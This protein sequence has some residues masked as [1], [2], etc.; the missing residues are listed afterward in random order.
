MRNRIIIAVIAFVT[1]LSCASCAKKEEDN[2]SS[3]G[4]SS[5]AEASSESAA[6]DS[7]ETSS[8]APEKSSEAD[9]QTPYETT[10]Q[11]TKETADKPYGETVDIN[12]YITVKE[13]DPPMWKVTDPDSGNTIYLLGTLHFVPTDVS[14]YPKDLIDIF[15]SC[16]SVA[17]EYDI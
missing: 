10:T 9:E 7:E 13:L 16:D 8:S 12:D 2:S 3:A 4:S 15:N 5:V 17:V 11:K 14:D 1:A 6:A